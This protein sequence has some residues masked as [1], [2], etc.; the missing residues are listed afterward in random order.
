VGKPALSFC[1]GVE[2]PMASHK[3]VVVS[4]VE[5]LALPI[6]QE[7]GLELW[8]IQFVKEGSTYYLRIF[9]DKDGGVS[10]DDCEAMSRAIDKELDRTDPIEQSYC[11]EVS[12]PGIE[13]SLTKDRHFEKYMGKKI[14]ARLIRPDASGRRDIEGTLESFDGSYVGVKTVSDTVLIKRAEAAYFRLA[15]NDGDD[16]ELEE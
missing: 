12:S 13:R 10:I 2:G 8:E 11:L 15:Y 1:L 6:A 4:E 16:F 9:I 5:K 14:K 3:G 7:L